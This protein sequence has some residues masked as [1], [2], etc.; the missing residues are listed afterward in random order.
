MWHPYWIVIMH[1]AILPHTFCC[2]H[3]IQVHFSL[4]HPIHRICL[5]YLMLIRSGGYFFSHFFRSRCWMSQTP[6]ARPTVRPHSSI[7]KTRGSTRRGWRPSWS[8]AGWTCE[9]HSLVSTTLSPSSFSLSFLPHQE[10]TATISEVLKC[11]PEKRN[12]KTSREQPNQNGHY[13]ACQYILG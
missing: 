7:R 6:I 5:C 1:K 2:V 4:C 3:C 8:R 13:L 9:L 11:H 12:K 10:K